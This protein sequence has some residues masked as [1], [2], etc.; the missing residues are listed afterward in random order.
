MIATTSRPVLGRTL[1]FA[2]LTTLTALAACE[3]RPS[4]TEL[5]TAD[6]LVDVTGLRGRIAYV[7]ST[8][9]ETEIWLFELGTADPVPERLTFSDQGGTA[10]QRPSWSPDG[11]RIAYQ[12]T[13]QHGIPGVYVMDVDG[14]DVRRIARDAAAPSWSPRGDEVAISNLRPD[15]RGLALVA[16][17]DP[18]PGVRQIT[19]VSG[20]V[21]EEYPAW[22]PDGARLVFNS[23]RSGGSDIWT[24]DRDG[25]NLTQLT[26]DPSL[27]NAPDWSPDGTRIAFNS[28]RTGESD[29]YLVDPDGSDLVRLTDSD[30]F[31]GGAVW[32]PDGRYI[33]YTA[34]RVPRRAEGNLGLWV[35]RADG[36]GATLLVDGP[37]EDLMLDWAP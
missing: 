36:T 9:E 20:G 17:A 16:W 3:A 29:I 13:D 33:A 35:M 25:Q 8:N 30:T 26:D 18:A 31:E 14:S 5:P 15:Q 2:G 11:T 23:Q 7:S 1:I 24:V 4:V 34:R 10:N 37:G 27:D 12:H 22:S 6:A 32:S 28:E 19:T 21:P